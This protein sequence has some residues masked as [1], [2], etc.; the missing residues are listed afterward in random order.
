METKHVGGLDAAAEAV[1]KIVDAAK[2]ADAK[3]VALVRERP[4]AALCAA[5]AAGYVVGRVISRLG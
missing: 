5:L 3:I 4:V 1:P 2:A